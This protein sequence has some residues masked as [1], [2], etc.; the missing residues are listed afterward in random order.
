MLI[1]YIQVVIQRKIHEKN[2]TFRV[3]NTKKKLKD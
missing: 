3:K 2:I 1:V